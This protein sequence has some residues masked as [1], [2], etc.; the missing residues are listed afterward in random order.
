MKISMYEASIP[1]FLHTLRNLKAI[2]QKGVAH[3]ESKST[4]RHCSPPRASRG[5]AAADAQIQIASDAAQGAAARLAG[6]DPPKFEDNETTIAELIARVD[7]TI[8][9]LQSF[10]PSSST[11]PMSA[12][13]RSRR[14]ARRSRSRD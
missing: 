6:V 9:Y 10:K 7:K 1:T 14:R 2:L 12:R 13:S 3:A 5:H 11:A 8:D 4:S